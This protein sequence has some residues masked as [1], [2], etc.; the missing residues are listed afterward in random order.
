V[1]RAFKEALARQ[2]PASALSKVMCVRLVLP[3]L[4]TG[5]LRRGFLPHPPP[6]SVLASALDAVA[7]KVVGNCF[8]VF[9]QDLRTDPARLAE[10]AA[11]LHALLDVG[12]RPGRCCS[13]M[14]AAE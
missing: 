6:P 7:T 2:G 13:G 10:Y 5:A 3:H 12:L 14:R 11:L 4:A 9:S 1:A 8:P